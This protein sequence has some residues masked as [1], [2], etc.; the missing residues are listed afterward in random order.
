[1]PVLRNLAS[2]FLASR[3]SLTSESQ[4]S[5]ELPHAAST[6]SAFAAVS[7]GRS[8]PAASR[9]WP[10]G[11]VADSGMGPVPSLTG[12]RGRS[13]AAAWCSS[14][15]A[16]FCRCFLAALVSGSPSLL[17]AADL[18]FGTLVSRAPMLSAVSIGQG[19]LASRS[20][21]TSGTASGSE[22]LVSGSLAASMF[23][24]FLTG[25]AFAQLL[26]ISPLLH[27]PITLQACLFTFLPLD[28]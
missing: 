28:T 20:P 6:R 26:S 14:A 4:L 11:S 18:S 9:G 15:A 23:S 19:A 22:A 27:V 21:T 24:S 16:S 8:V 1:M 25:S 17:T 12:E 5:P 7:C 13:P 3:R 2:V 10:P